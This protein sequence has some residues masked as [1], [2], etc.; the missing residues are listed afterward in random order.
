M[1]SRQ[2]HTK[3]NTQAAY[4]PGLD[5]KQVQERL[6]RDGLNELSSTRPRSVLSKAWEVV[7]EPMFLLLISCGILYLIIGNT[8][9]AF[10]LLGSVCLIVTMSFLQER[11]SERTLE[12][13]RELTSPR[14]LVLRDGIRKRIAG[15]DVVSDDIVFLSEGDRIPADAIVLEAQNL[16][17]DESLLTGE[18]V[19]VRK[20]KWE[21]GNFPE[22]K[23]GGDDLPYLF[24]GTL[25][26][27]GK[28]IARVTA[29]G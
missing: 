26:V 2:Q 6:L 5:E 13:L 11:K 24:S 12:A 1:M 4:F 19:P 17:V 7:S 21:P 15:K 10:I 8:E 20:Q 9:D 27:Q 28:G 14:A 25:V 23:P 18:S 3:E 22:N 16:S 29:T